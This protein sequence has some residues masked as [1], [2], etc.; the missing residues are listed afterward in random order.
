MSA[1][2]AL[3][4]GIIETEI[5]PRTAR[6]MTWVFVGCI[7]GLPLIQAASELLRGE[8][9]QV[10]QVFMRAPTQANLHAYEEN[11][12]RCSLARTFVQPLL[13]EQLSMRGGFGNHKVILG[14]D[15]WLFYQPG[16][17]YLMGAPI[18]SDIRIG[19]RAKKVVD[20]HSILASPDPRPAMLDFHR[21]CAEQGIRL[22]IM[23]V[24]D[25]AMLEASRLTSRYAPSRTQ[26]PLNNPDYEKLVRELRA[27]GVD[28]FE[29][30][31]RQAG[32][33]DHFLRQDTHWTPQW[34]D[35]TAMDLA[36]HLRASVQWSPP[37]KK[38]ALAAVS[39]QVGRVGDLVDMLQLPKDQTVFP[40]QRV[41]IGRIVDA[42][43]GRPVQAD[44]KSEVLLLGDSF[45]N[46]Y[47]V[48]AMGWGDAAGFVEHLSFHLGFPVDRITQNDAGAHATRG[49]LARELARDPN[50]L[51]GKK[52]I[53]WEFAMRELTSGEWRPVPMQVRAAAERKPDAPAA[54][55]FLV[56]PPGKTVQVTAT[57]R[58]ASHVPT[59]GS[60]PYKDHIMALHLD[61]L[62]ADEESLGS[63]QA[64]VYAWSMRDNVLTRA[65]GLH[66]GDRVTLRLKAWPELA[67]KLGSINRSE[68]DDLD[69]QLE[70]PNWGEELP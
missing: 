8:T 52:A 25:K 19:D 4:K 61:G 64:L 45:S 56:V 35:A 24:P 2:E 59:P 67:P 16:I 11:L 48:E 36:E 47:S 14:E 32:E 51:A 20:E 17:E 13:Q 38:A 7:F 69:L 26:G 6:W 37:A 66:A 29:P 1:E 9:P 30:Q 28:V 57:V 23:P 10:L 22:V 41:Q 12:A 21:F 44:P 54:D 33:M 15:G 65:A 40:P 53:V 5:S 18:L 70:T 39:V 63:R 3:K 27:A 62:S 34:M 55:G 68:L 31:A 46:I 50:R 49:M 43:S 58:A 60:V 42:A